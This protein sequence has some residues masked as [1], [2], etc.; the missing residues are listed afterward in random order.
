M[1]TDI[2]A[3]R[4]AEK[5]LRDAWYEEDRRFM[6]Q[7]ITML[8]A[9]LWDGDKEKTSKF[10][11]NTYKQIHDTIALELGVEW[12][13]DRWMFT[14]NTINGNS[15]RQTYTWD[16]PN[17]I[18]NYLNKGHEGPRSADAFIKD[19]LSLIEQGFRY[20]WQIVQYQNVEL[21]TTLANAAHSDAQFKKSFDPNKPLQVSSSPS[22]NATFGEL[23]RTLTK[24]QLGSSEQKARDHNAQLNREFDSAV[25]ELNERLR[26]A[27]YPLHFHNGH[28]QFI[29][30]PTTAEQIHAPFWGLVSAPMWDNVDLQMKEA[31]DRRDNGDRTAAFHAVCALESAIKII[32]GAKGWTTG[33]EGGARNFLDNLGSKRAG[34]FLEEWEKKT[35]GEMFSDVRNPFAHG[36]G[37]AAMPSLS[38]QQTNWAIDT[39][40][41]WTK[42]LIQR[43]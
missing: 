21:P 9:V 43:M 3:R 11:D 42:S 5:P 39:A 20:R 41:S 2:F 18:R 8:K 34:N 16:Y 7:A 13:S 32:S 28:L 4:Y 37:Q 10:T 35:L 1:L 6:V 25:A 24:M 22:V 29:E 15:V 40:M 31:I 12:L 19:R 36:P 33:K 14:N 23:H 26:L 27:S 38:P 30:D 17:I